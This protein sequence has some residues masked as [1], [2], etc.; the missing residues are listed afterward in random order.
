MKKF[1]ELLKEI[2][3]GSNVSSEEELDQAVKR[4]V[5]DNFEFEDELDSDTLGVKYNQYSDY[6]KVNVRIPPKAKNLNWK[7][8]FKRHGYYISFRSDNSLT[9]TFGLFPYD[10]EPVENL[11]GPLFHITPR[12]KLLKIKKKGLVPQK[13]SKRYDVAV[14]RIYFVR[15]NAKG[16]DK[17]DQLKG[18]LKET[19]PEKPPF[20]NLTATL[21]IDPSMTD[22]TFYKDPEISTWGLFTREN[23][24]PQAIQNFEEYQYELE[25]LRD[26]I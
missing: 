6:G 18:S 25:K 5:Y 1:S 26:N 21:E 9:T 12:N 15:N 14:A 3:I 4:R 11:S 7:N 22:V 16:R 2:R 17:L 13:S 20:G 23:V 8:F 19:I 10:T 24:R